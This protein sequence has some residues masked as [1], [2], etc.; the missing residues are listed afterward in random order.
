MSMVGCRTDLRNSHN[1]IVAGSEGEGTGGDAPDG[2]R[3]PPMRGNH[4]LNRSADP[5]QLPPGVWPLMSTN[6]SSLS[7]PFPTSLGVSGIASSSYIADTNAAQAIPVGG[8]LDAPGGGAAHSGTEREGE[9]VV[10]GARVGGGSGCLAGNNYTSRHHQRSQHVE[11]NHHQQQQQQQQQDWGYQGVMRGLRAPTTSSFAGRSLSLTSGPAATA[12]D[13]DDPLMMRPAGGVDFDQHEQLARWNQAGGV[14]SDGSGNPYERGSGPLAS[15]QHATVGGGGRSGGGDLAGW[16]EFN[17]NMAL[18][19]RHGKMDSA[20]GG[21]GAASADGV[22]SDMGISVGGHGGGGLVASSR[23]SSGVVADTS[24]SGGGSGLGWVGQ[25]DALAAP[26]SPPP[27]TEQLAVRQ[28]MMK[29]L[30]PLPSHVHQQG[31]L[32]LP[33]Q[34][35]QQQQHGMPVS[36]VMSAFSVPSSTQGG[37]GGGVGSV[38]VPAMARRGSPNATSALEALGV[39]VGVNGNMNTFRSSM[40]MPLEATT[41][42]GFG[43]GRTG[44]GNGATVGSSPM[45]STVGQH[46]P[47][48]VSGVSS[49]PRSSSPSDGYFPSSVDAAGDGSLHDGGDADG[50]WGNTGSGQAR[51]SSGVG[52]GSTSFLEGNT[53]LA[54]AA[55]AASTSVRR[56]R[57]S[58]GMKGNVGGSTAWSGGGS[59]VLQSRVA[60]QPLSA[61]SSISFDR[62]NGVWTPDF[63]L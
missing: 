38:S 52:P 15:L 21:I 54:A 29:R 57:D 56:A 11:Q 42:G 3:L 51:V 63:P 39:R 34:Q 33:S 27:S 59:Q 37:G 48:I 26:P 5:H 49:S 36:P 31:R 12:E 17:A 14:S 55:A 53:A 62:E 50:G 9:G 4:E 46:N 24:R 28:Q 40:A 13:D 2:F 6:A 10:G 23:S 19:S 44:G 43:G 18:P 45:W 25:L 61:G 7:H 20:A 22:T 32:E 58:F 16:E 60:Q 30:P 35:H 1:S 47:S 8:G 41:D